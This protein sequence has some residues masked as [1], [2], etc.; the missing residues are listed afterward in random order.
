MVTVNLAA[1]GAHRKNEVTIAVLDSTG[2][3]KVREIE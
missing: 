2:C 1:T 3:A